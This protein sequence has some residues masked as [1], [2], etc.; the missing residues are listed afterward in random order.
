ML[1]Q[2]G[3]PVKAVFAG[4]LLS[5]GFLLDLVDGFLVPLLSEDS[6][7]SSRSLT[8]RYVV[9]EGLRGN[10]EGTVRRQRCVF[11]AKEVGLRVE[12]AVVSLMTVLEKLSRRRRKRVLLALGARVVISQA[13]VQVGLASLVVL[14]LA[15][16]WLLF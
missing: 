16:L 6:S 5:E 2:L 11:I 15:V 7:L 3:R 8:D 10:L 9:L 13:R 14:D 1:F 12:R 4:S